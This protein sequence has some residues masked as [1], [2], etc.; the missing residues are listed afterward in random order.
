MS[1]YE[2]KS[3]YVRPGYEAYLS[4]LGR[5]HKIVEG[6]KHFMSVGECHKKLQGFCLSGE[7][8]DDVRGRVNEDEGEVH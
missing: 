6:L 5:R 1:G 2:G 4:R 7:P 8:K 3:T